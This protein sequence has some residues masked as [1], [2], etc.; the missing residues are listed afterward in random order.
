MPLRLRRQSFHLP[1]ADVT[2]RKIAKYGWTPDLPDIRDWLFSR[3][4]IMLPS[5]V[6]LR[7]LCPPVYDQGALGSCT[8]N[9]IAGAIQFLRMKESL[10]DFTP[11]RL[12]IYYDERV[13]EGTADYDAGAAIRDGIKSVAQTGA[14][15]ET[16]WP[17]DIS[18]FTAKPPQSAYDAAAQDVALQYERID[19]TVLDDLRACLAGGYPFV[20]GFT[21]YESFESP[22]T[23]K[24]GV[25][26]M[27]HPNEGIVGGHAVCGVG[28]DDKSNVFICRN[29]WSDAWGKVGYFTIPYDYLTNDNLASDFWKISVVGTE[30]TAP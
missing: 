14:C 13:M 2:I 24:T 4:G 30:T 23:A 27:P 5:Q 21:V 22:E 3:A 19:N 28:Y 16:L 7:P 9:A 15:D 6:D 18:Q 12:M 20:C 10:S 1:V 26:K 25:A 11:S 8:G 29:S 17:Y